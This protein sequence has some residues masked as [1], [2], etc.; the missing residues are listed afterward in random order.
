MKRLLLTML[1]CLAAACKQGGQAP[2]AEPVAGAEMIAYESPRGTFSCMA[3]ADWKVQEGVVDDGVI[4]FGPPGASI[5]VLRHGSDAAAYARSYWEVAEDRRPPVVEKKALGGLDAL[6]FHTERP[7]RKPHSSKIEY[8]T[9][10]DH[11]LIPAKGG[12]FEVVHTAPVDSYQRTLP[13]F[14][15]LVSGFKPKG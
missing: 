10:K 13:I 7:F 6:V 8:M 5:S 12:F 3:P 9:R 14:E 11:A 15:A 1:A 4:F 2:P